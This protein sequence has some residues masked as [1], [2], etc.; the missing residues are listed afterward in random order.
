MIALTD[1]PSFSAYATVCFQQGKYWGL[2]HVL[3]ILKN[4]V[5]K[6]APIFMRRQGISK[7]KHGGSGVSLLGVSL[8]GLC[9]VCLLGFLLN[10]DPRWWSSNVKL[11]LQK[12]WV[13]G[14]EGEVL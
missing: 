10:A 11:L 8:K 13:R 3:L 2:M 9:A 1:E 7:L 4:G 12:V 6:S 5:I 14:F